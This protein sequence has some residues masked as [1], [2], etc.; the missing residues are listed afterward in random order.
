MHMA[1]YSGNIKLMMDMISA[2]GDLRLHDNAGRTAKEWAV[3]QSEPKKRLKM[4][5]FIEKSTL[6]AM[7][8]SGGDIKVNK[9]KSQINHTSRYLLL[10]VL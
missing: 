1:A 7:T 5:E 2:G 3:A 6:F 10:C 4:V 9:R 8:Q